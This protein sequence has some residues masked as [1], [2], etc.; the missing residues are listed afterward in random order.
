MF[1][2]FCVGSKSQKKDHDNDV[3]AEVDPGG[4][5][6]DMGQSGV[7]FGREAKRGAKRGND[8]DEQDD[9]AFTLSFSTENWSYV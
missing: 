4:P 8:I 2:E 3:F 6:E 9:N 7:R 5:E 1:V